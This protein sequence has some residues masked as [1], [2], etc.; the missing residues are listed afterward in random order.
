[1]R[2]GVLVTVD[3]KFY[4]LLGCDTVYFGRQVPTVSSNLQLQIFGIEEISEKC[5]AVTESLSNYQS[6]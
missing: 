5:I 3:M 4:D 6:T 1:M 2:F